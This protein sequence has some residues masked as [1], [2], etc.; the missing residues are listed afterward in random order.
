MESLLIDIG[1]GISALGVGYGI[2]H[3][4]A[5][6]KVVTTA[7]R[8]C[9]IWFEKNTRSYAQMDVIYHGKSII[10]NSCPSL[11]GKRCKYTDKKCI[12]L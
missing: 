6:S 10:T 1:L 12:L 3:Q 8:Q 5:S 7:K 9:D 11:I 2:G 4:H